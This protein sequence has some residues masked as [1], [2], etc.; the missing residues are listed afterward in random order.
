MVVLMVVFIVIMASRI[1]EK[2]ASLKEAKEAAVKQAVEPVR[3]IVLSL[4][5]RRVVDRIDLPAEVEPY[6]DLWVKAEVTGQIIKV[7]VEE[8]QDV[9]KGQVLVQLD[10]RDYR[11]RLARIDANYRLAKVERDRIASLVKR[12]VT[13]VSEL[14]NV[15][16]RLRDLAAQRGEAKLALDRTRITSPISGRIN[17]IKAKLG[18]FLAVGDPVAHILQFDRVKVSVGVPESD[19]AA[20][21]DLKEAE[22]VIDALNGLRIK[23]T[24]VFLSLQPRTLARLYDLELRIPNPDGR[25]LP[26]MFARVELVKAVFDP[27][28]TVPLYAVITQGD[29]RFVFVDRQGKAERRPVELGV[30]DGWQVQITTGLKPGERVVVVG[31]RLLDEGQPLEVISVVNDPQEI[32]KS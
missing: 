31:H 27:A 32:L 14:D 25:I 18:G 15:E 2:K 21:F 9:E 12:K 30:L 4:T 3:V 24:K 13:P 7:P 11:A 6:E 28:L 10:D 29:Q 8:G 19:V 1:V 26:G 22:V 16:A 17:E 5:P 20:V 23:G